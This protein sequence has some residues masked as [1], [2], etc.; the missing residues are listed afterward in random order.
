MAPN[1]S[2]DLRLRVLA[3]ILSTAQTP[4]VPGLSA[5][6]FHPLHH[7]SSPHH[8]FPVIGASFVLVIVTV[9]H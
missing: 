6:H 4:R 3:S 9:L 1:R 7:S 5:L 8:V 2:E